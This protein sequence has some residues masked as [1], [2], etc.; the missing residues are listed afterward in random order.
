MGIQ[1]RPL[2]VVIPLLLCTGPKHLVAS[3]LL[4]LSPIAIAATLIVLLIIS[5]WKR[6]WF[7]SDTGLENPYKTVFKITNF[8]RKKQASL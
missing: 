3:G 8:A 7:Y 2:M 5:W 6:H 1:I 4:L